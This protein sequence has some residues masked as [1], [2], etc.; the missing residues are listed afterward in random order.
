MREN[1]NIPIMNLIKF[2]L[3]HNRKEIVGTIL[4]LSILKGTKNISLSPCSRRGFGGR[5]KIHLE[6]ENKFPND[7]E[8]IFTLR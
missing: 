7:L 5:F 2:P 6:Y 8:T 3:V 1:F 4:L